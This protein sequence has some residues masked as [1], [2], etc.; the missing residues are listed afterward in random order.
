MGAFEAGALW[1]MYYGLDD[2]S[3]M[4]YDVVT[5]VSA[6]ALNGGAV[7]LFGKGQEEALIK[8]M[9]DLWNSIND[10]TV[11]GD[12]TPENLAYNL[13]NES[14]ILNDTNLLSFMAEVEANFSNT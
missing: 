13:V 9:S 8:Y 2:K 14:G 1:G 12:P 3:K 10:T 4:E 7:A 5:G 11:F 6:G